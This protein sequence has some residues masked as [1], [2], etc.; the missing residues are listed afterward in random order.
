V[1]PAAPPPADVVE[2]AHAGLAAGQTLNALTG[3]VHAAGWADRCGAVALVREDVGRHNALDKLI[4]ALL[5]SGLPRADGMVVV[6]SRA[7]YEMVHK[8]ASAGIGVLSAV[9]APTALA[10]RTARA[11][12]LALLGFSRG[13]RH[14]VYAPATDSH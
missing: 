2:R 3:A 4:G 13:G 12:G 5:R 1:Q 6:T 9:S 10:V 7:S 11:A 8:T 14:T